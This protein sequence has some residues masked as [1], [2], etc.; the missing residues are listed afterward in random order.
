MRFWPRVLDRLRDHHN[1]TVRKTS[2]IRRSWLGFS[3]DIP[4]VGG[5]VNFAGKKGARADLHLS[6]AN[7]E[8]NKA[9]FDLLHDQHKERVEEAIGE[10]LSWERL[11]NRKACRIAL[12]LPGR[13]IE[14][15]ESTLNDTA[16]WMVDR[17][18]R[19]RQVMIPIVREAAREVDDSI[20]SISADENPW[21]EEGKEDGE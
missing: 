9:L 6:A 8:R 13:S 20:G 7:K 21:E 14:D 18:V 5:V 17:F 19:L 2:S 16:D 4:G 3:S 15:S 12:Y 10:P 11:G 1:L